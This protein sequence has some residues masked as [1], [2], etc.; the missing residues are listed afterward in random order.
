MFRRSTALGQI[1]AKD[2]K[3]ISCIVPYCAVERH[4]PRSESA[5]PCYP[6]RPGSLAQRLQCCP[7]RSRSCFR[8]LVGPLEGVVGLLLQ[9]SL[10]VQLEHL[11]VC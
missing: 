6:A 3:N 9:A 5:C 2:P 8:H 10:V 11:Q 1:E 4:T 7:C